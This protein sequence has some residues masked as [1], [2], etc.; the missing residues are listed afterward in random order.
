[1][2]KLRLFRLYSFIL[3]PV[4]GVGGKRNWLIPK[5][6]WKKKCVAK[7][8]PLIA[9]RERERDNVDAMDHKYKVADVGGNQLISKAL[10]ERT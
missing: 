2:M 3:L 10:A 4:W 8:N 1:M 6:I 5:R 7:V 9:P